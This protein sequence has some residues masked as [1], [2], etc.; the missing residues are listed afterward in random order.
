MEWE[1]RPRGKYERKF[2]TRRSRVPPQWLLCPPTPKPLEH[3]VSSSWSWPMNRTWFVKKDWTRLRDLSPTARGNYLH[4]THFV[5]GKGN[6][7]NLSETPDFWCMVLSNW[8]ICSLLRQFYPPNFPTLL[9]SY[10]RGQFLLPQREEG[11]KWEKG[12]LPTWDA[13]T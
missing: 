9:L 3:V 1:K 7:P 4:D 2:R 11:W 6:S 10:W 12:I 5:M 13:C 8:T